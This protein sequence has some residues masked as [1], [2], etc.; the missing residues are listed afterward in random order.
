MDLLDGSVVEREFDS[1]VLAT[2]NVAMNDVQLE[3]GDREDFDIHIIGDGLSPRQAPA[4]T[5]EGRMTGLKL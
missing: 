1:L 3:L 5:Y 4:A 2:V